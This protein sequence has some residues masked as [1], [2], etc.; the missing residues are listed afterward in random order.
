[1][2]NVVKKSVLNTAFGR[3]IKVGLHLRQTP[4][5]FCLRQN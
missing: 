1:L 2:F 3:K 5:N 4:W